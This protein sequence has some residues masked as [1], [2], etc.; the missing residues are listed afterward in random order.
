[1]PEISR[2]RALTYAAVVL[3]VVSL[4]G[5]ALVP[6]APDRTGAAAVAPRLTDATEP[7]AKVVVHVVGAVE[8]PGL[9]RLDEGSRVDDAIT[10]AGGATRR[11]S[12]AAVNLAAPVAD[13]QQI[14]VPT[15]TPSPGG[16]ASDPTAAEGGAAAGARVHLNSATLEELDALPGVGPVTAQNIIDYRAE[17]GAFGSVDELD[18]VSGIGPARLEQL[19]EVVDL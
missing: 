12:L 15:R 2:R 8:R 9:Y 11:A 3:V 14:A 18:A 7:P 13:G 10:K 1:M 4:A 5:R 6:P 19:R 17:N 16:A